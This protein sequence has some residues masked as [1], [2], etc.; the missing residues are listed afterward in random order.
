VRSAE[1]SFANSS[2]CAPDTREIILYANPLPRGS[3]ALSASCGRRPRRQSGGSAVAR[4]SS[5]P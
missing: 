5:G 1:R 2:S 4:S 3:T